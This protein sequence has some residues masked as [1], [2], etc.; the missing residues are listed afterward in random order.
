[1]KAETYRGVKLKVKKGR[2]WGYLA[3]FVNGVPWG[4]WIGT[5]EAKALA[6]MHGYVDDAIARPDAYA[7]YWQ[8][9]FKKEQ[10]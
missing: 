1:M 6:G 8:P 3:H 4:E 2:D 10:S 9:G 7:D 5:D